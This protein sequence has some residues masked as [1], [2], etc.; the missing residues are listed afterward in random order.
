[1][2]QTSSASQCLQARGHLDVGMTTGFQFTVSKKSS[3]SSICVHWHLISSPLVKKSDA[4]F[5]SSAEH[6]VAAQGSA[7]LPPSPT[8]SI[9]LVVE[10]SEARAAV[11]LR[12]DALENANEAIQTDAS[13]HYAYER[14]HVALHG[15]GRYDEA[16]ET[17]ENMLSMIGQSGDPKIRRLRNK[18]VSTSQKQKAIEDTIR[19]TINHG[20]L[21]LIDVTTGRLCDRQALL[22]LFRTD[23]AFKELVSSMTGEINKE[24]IRETINKYFGYVM[25]SHVWGNGKQKRKRMNRR[26]RRS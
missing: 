14:K 24:R 7:A 19:K 12:E 3:P 25:F 22:D 21:V 2:P 4:L 17:Y 10:R 18:Y 9:D 11:K 16:I 26:S 13:C 23:P 5:D 6:V 8:G 1:M 15:M 20:P